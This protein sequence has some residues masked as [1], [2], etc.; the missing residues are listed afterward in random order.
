MG[1]IHFVMG[2]AERPTKPRGNQQEKTIGKR[3]K[4]YKPKP[5]K[6]CRCDVS[7]VM[8]TSG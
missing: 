6:V 3:K 7:R 5:K 2:K 8:L 1:L 4:F